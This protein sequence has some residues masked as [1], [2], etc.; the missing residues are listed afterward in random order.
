MKLNTRNRVYFR[1]C[2]VAMATKMSVGVQALWL[3]SWNV[4]GTFQEVAVVL[5]TS[6]LFIKFSVS[7]KW[8]TL[9]N[10]IKHVVTVNYFAS[11]RKGRGDHLLAPQTREERG[12]D[13][14]LAPQTGEGRVS[15]QLLAPQKGEG[16][17]LSSFGSSDGGGGG[18][19]QLL[20]PQKGE[21]KG[22]SSFGS[23]DGGGEGVWSTSGSSEGRGEGVI[24][25]WLL[26]RGRGGGL[27]N[28]WLRFYC[29][30]PDCFLWHL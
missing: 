19:D 2:Q 6:K 9:S 25:F 8:K 14:L 15:D 11:E 17:G 1:C 3:I 30:T 18:S 27:I 22:W 28:F 24:I 26:R 23:S 13:Q 16:K 12:S 29:P 20:T 21:E 5:Q 7:G 10:H 4:V